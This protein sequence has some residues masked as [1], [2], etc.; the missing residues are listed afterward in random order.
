MSG[1][2]NQHDI[3]RRQRDV[4]NEII[5]RQDEKTSNV[6]DEIANRLY[7]RPSTIWN[8]LKQAKE[9]KLIK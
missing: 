9:N 8:D 6:V 1:K 4:A 2:K 3:E 5:L 7:L